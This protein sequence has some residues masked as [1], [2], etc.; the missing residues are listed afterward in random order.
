MNN[1]YDRGEEGPRYTMSSFNKDLTPLIDIDDAEDDS[2]AIVAMFLLVDGTTI[3][4]HY[5]ESLANASYVLDNPLLVT[6][7]ST[8]M[9][10][11]NYSS[12]VAY[13]VW[14]PLSKER[15]FTVPKSRIIT[16]TIPLDTLVGT[17]LEHKNNG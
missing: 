6:I 2:E 16:K 14:M 10:D 15:T 1:D 5:S 3:V 13:D 8:A 7:E 4:S 12:S 11:G 17:Y 9:V